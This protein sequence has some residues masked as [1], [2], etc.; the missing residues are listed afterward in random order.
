M[1]FVNTEKSLPIIDHGFEASIA[2][3]TT[4]AIEQAIHA[5]FELLERVTVEHRGAVLRAFTPLS[6]LVDIELQPEFRVVGGEA[7]YHIGLPTHSSEQTQQSS[8]HAFF[9]VDPDNWKIDFTITP[10]ATIPNSANNPVQ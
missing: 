10:S 2:A 8:S 1:S 9:G 3:V 6:G 5:D 4:R 7:H